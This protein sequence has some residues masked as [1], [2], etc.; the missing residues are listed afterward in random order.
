MSSKYSTK[1]LFCLT[2]RWYVGLFSKKLNK[3][4][5]ISLNFR[6]NFRQNSRA[7]I[8]TRGTYVLCVLTCNLARRI[9]LWPGV[10]SV[11]VYCV[12]LVCITEHSLIEFASGSSSLL[13]V[14][15]V[16]V[17]YCKR[18]IQCLASSEILTPHPLTAP[19]LV[20]GRTHLL[21]GEGVGGQSFGTRQTL[22]CTLYICKY[23]V[24]G[25]LG[26]VPRIF[27]NEFRALTPLK[28]HKKIIWFRLNIAN[29]IRK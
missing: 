20:R 5:S 24:V 1:W 18:P 16:E 15:S 17:L 9:R 4:K 8:S 22:L 23:F 28:K 26:G 14:G 7:Q 10:L 13:W 12:Y 21:G 25:S 11:C 3:E 19:P 6:K 27:Y 29:K 2:C